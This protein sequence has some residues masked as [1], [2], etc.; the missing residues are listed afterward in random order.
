MAHR[1]HPIKAVVPIGGGHNSQLIS[2]RRCRS[3]SRNPVRCENPGP[4]PTGPGAVTGSAPVGGGP[5]PR[6]R[7]RPMHRSCHRRRLQPFP[8]ARSVHS[9]TPEPPDRL[10]GEHRLIRRLFP[11]SPPA[12][13]GAQETRGVRLPSSKSSNSRHGSTTKNAR[14]CSALGLRSRQRGS[15]RRDRGGFPQVRSPASRAWTG[16]VWVQ[17]RDRAR[18]TTRAA[19]LDVRGQR[20]GYG[21]RSASSCSSWRRSVYCRTRAGTLCSPP[22]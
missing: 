2:R 5:T 16:P 9:G 15:V 10:W 11:N 19:T 1:V 4:C 20:T 7:T 6:R 3:M 17:L 13:S 21:A 14:A 22:E 12:S 8:V 18:W